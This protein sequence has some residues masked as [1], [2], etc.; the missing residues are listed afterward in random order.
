MSMLRGKDQAAAPP[1]RK[2]KF[3]GCEIIY[4]EACF[5]AATGP[6]RVDVE[7]LLKGLHDLP[8]QD[9]LAKLQATVDAAS[10]DAG[11]EAILLGYARCN[12]GLVGL[13]A[14]GIPLV[15]P[16]AHDCI[17]FLFGS[18]ASYNEYFNEHPGTYFLSTGWSERNLFGES[19]YSTPAYGQR[20]VMANLGLA[21][22]YEAMVEKYGKENADFIVESM[23]GWLKNYSRALYLEMGVCDEAAFMEKAKADAQSRGWEFLT[24]KG[25]WSLLK[26]LFNLQWH[27]DFQIVPPGSHLVARNDESVLGAEQ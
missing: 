6:N 26:K 10:A 21:E 9:M 23:G 20:G 22:P 3:I 15:I 18:R 13:T 5:L 1:V 12:D 4:R 17:T 7:F 25:D 19:G 8:R 27:D 11:Y 14:R 2:F 16:R 24:R